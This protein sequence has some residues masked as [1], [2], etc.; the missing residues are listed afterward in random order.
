MDHEIAMSEGDGVAGD[1]EEAE[2]ILDRERAFLREVV[3]RHAVDPLHHQIGTTVG[4][5][6]TVDD[7]S[8]GRVLEARE[9]AAL[10]PEASEQ[11]LG[12]E[13]ATNDLD[14]DRL[15]EGAVVALA[16]VDVG[17]AA[18]AE[19]AD[20]AKRSCAL[21]RVLRRRG[22]LGGRQADRLIEELV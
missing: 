7:A 2:T 9:N 16:G 18:A 17:H 21:R 15:L 10:A 8:D 12:V 4:Q 13:A 19:E 11:V 3:D 6:S 5:R 1:Q 14:G 20:D 22:R